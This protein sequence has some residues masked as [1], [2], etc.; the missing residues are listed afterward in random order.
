MT[1]FRINPASKERIYSILSHATEA[2]IVPEIDEVIGYN[3]F[4]KWLIKLLA[5]KGIAYRVINLGAGIKRIITVD[6][7]TCPKCNGT[8][9]V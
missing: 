8:G 5:T 4:A 2:R 6:F 3:P 9:R 1:K 7:D